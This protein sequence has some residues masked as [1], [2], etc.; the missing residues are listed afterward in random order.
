MRISVCISTVRPITLRTAIESIRGQTWTDWEL[1][2]VGQG[3]SARLEAA[4]REAAHDE[5]R[6]RYLHSPRRGLSIARNAGVQ[7]ANGE[8]IAFTDDDCEARADWLS[9]L[10]QCFMDEPEIGLVGGSVVPPKP[11]RQR[12]AMCPSMIPD[13]TLYDPVACR[14]QPPRGFEWLGAN[15]AIR[16]SVAERVGPFDECL[17]SGAAFPAAEDTD[18]KLRLEALGVKMRA[19]P[20]AVIYHTFGYRYGLRAVLRNSRNYA[21]GNAGLAGKLTLLGDPRGEEWRLA[22]KRDCTRGWLRPPRPHRLPAGLWRLRHFLRAYERCLHEYQ[23]IDGLLQP[24]R[25]ER[26]SL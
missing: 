17:G 11:L 18:Y 16:R 23:A 19:T 25:L 3:H 12:F 21:E 9:T 5:P 24:R 7:T 1:I 2:V 6:V 8:I 14:R 4:T 15:F 10:A 20:R 13:E 22:T 26:V